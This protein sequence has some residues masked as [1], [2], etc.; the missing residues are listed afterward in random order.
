MC[1]CRFKDC[2]SG[3]KESLELQVKRLQEELDA[4]RKTVNSDCPAEHSRRS[5]LFL[6]MFYS[7]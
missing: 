1:V 3:E 5:L 4:V 7:L 6:L 2:L